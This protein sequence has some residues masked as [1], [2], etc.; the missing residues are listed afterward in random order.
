MGM[1]EVRKETKEMWKQEKK[2]EAVQSNEQ[3]NTEKSSEEKYE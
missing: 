1:E 3:I 2:E